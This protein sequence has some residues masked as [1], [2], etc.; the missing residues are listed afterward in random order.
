VFTTALAA[1]LTAQTEA[2]RGDIAVNYKL[3]KIMNERE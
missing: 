2:S 1:Y 3:G